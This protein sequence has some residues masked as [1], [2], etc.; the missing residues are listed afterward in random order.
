MRYYW[1]DT[2]FPEFHDDG[3]DAAADILPQMDDDCLFDAI[4]SAVDNMPCALPDSSQRI[5]ITSSISI[6]TLLP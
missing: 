1:L 4:N 3:D 2:V 6:D 5:G